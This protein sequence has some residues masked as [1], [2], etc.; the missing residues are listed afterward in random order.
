[1]LN[2]NYIGALVMAGV[3]LSGCGGGDA[4]NTAAPASTAAATTAATT[5]T[6][7]GDPVLNQTGNPAYAEIALYK[8]WLSTNT[9]PGQ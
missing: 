5:S 6:G 2:K 3:T 1:M 9:D 7:I 8:T 4:Q